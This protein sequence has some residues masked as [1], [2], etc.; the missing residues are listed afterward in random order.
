[1]SEVIFPLATVAGTFLVLVPVLTLASRAA[2]ALSRRRCASWARFGS[3]TNYAWLVGPTLLPV[4][5]VTSSALHH[6]EPTRSLGACLIDHVQGTTCV[7][8]LLLIG[9]MF[10][11]LLLTVVFR[12]WREWPRTALRR[13]GNA[14]ELSRRVNEITR[15][16]PHLRSLRVAVVQHATEPVVTVGLL[17]P[18]VLI[19]ACF[20][21]GADPQI[22]RAALLH[23]RAHIAGLDTF[24]CF[25]ARLCLSLNPAGALLVADFERWRSAREAMC[26]G[27]AVERGGEPLA[28]AEGILR[29]A[30]FRCGDLPL[31]AVS[32]CGHDAAAL[33]LRIALLLEGPPPPVRSLGHAFLALGI[34]GVLAIPHL[35]DIG[36]LEQFHFAVERL[37]HGPTS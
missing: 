4:I 33:K 2:L 31:H 24:R 27:E 25:V 37:F 13:L 17:R 14:H 26:D 35:G 18:L 6:S 8:T 21:R 32:L 20:V 29:A 30:R 10:A 28:L 19:D 12:L 5:W 23:E 11:G 36:L 34:V 9:A 1:M 7:D 3:E 22:L 15:G 16:D